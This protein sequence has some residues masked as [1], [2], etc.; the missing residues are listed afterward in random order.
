MIVGSLFSG[1]G[2]I[3]IGFEKA[4]F[5]TGWFIENDLYAQQVLRK[6]FPQAKIY[7][8]IKDIDFRTVPKVDILTGGF[9]CQDISNAGKRAGIEG[10]RSS[11]WKYY[12]EAIRTLRPRFAFIENVSALLNRGL[13][14]VLADLA[15]IGYDAEWHCVPASAIGANHKRD[16]IYILAYPDINPNRA[17]PGETEE[18]NKIP[19]IN[20]EERCSRV[21]G[22]TNNEISRTDKC[23][24][25]HRQAE[26]QSTKGRKPTQCKSRPSS[27][28]VANTR[29]C[30]I[31]GGSKRIQSE[32][33]HDAETKG[34]DVSP[35]GWWA[36]EPGLGRVADGIPNRVDRIKCL[37]NA[38]VP[39]VA[40]V[41][42]KAI[43]EGE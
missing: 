17:W 41:F 13:H 42:A 29:K 8:D 28:D 9:P 38:V 15:K 33:K 10:S 5:E 34:R 11:L 18:K 16:R 12:L 7:G 37:G 32:K 4:G 21:P 39:Q 35:N 30:R 6:Q 19:S 26:E 31:F 24:L 3:E 14:V 27:E 23:G 1:I 25:L 22:R 36:T 40:E 2:G 20:R 43:K